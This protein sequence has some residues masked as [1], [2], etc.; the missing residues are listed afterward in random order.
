MFFWQLPPFLMFGIYW[1]FLHPLFR[2][3]NQ[4]EYEEMED[5]IVKRVKR[6][7]DVK[8]GLYCVLSLLVWCCLIIGIVLVLVKS[9]QRNKGLVRRLIH[10]PGWLGWNSFVSL[11]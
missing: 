4:N 2:R 5:E 9:D 11:R 8:W 6:R 1:A 7:I 3:K 10:C